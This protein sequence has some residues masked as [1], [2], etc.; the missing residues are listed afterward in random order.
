MLPGRPKLSPR[1]GLWRLP[2]NLYDPRED[3][4]SPRG[5]PPKSIDDP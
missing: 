1:L 2:Y 4:T 5:A 3:V